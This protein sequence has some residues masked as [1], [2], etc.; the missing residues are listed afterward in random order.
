MTLLAAPLR[1]LVPTVRTGAIAVLD[2]TASLSDCSLH[3]NVAWLRGGALEVASKTFVSLSDCS[4]HSTAPVTRAQLRSRRM[5]ISRR[6]RAGFGG[7][8][9]STSKGRA[10][11]STSAYSSLE[12]AD[13]S[14]SVDAA[15]GAGI[16]APFFAGLHREHSFSDCGGRAFRAVILIMDDSSSHHLSTTMTTMDEIS[17]LRLIDGVT[18]DNLGVPAV[19]GRA[20]LSPTARACAPRILTVSS[21]SIALL[22][23]PSARPALPR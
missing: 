19:F 20:S 23:A 5:P 3:S 1:T 12:L 8:K 15:R 7:T 10:A 21:S 16:R 13:S 4:L 22:P 9:Q 11:L 14:F 2:H 18:F 17:P 6:A